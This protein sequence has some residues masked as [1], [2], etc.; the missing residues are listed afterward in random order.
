MSGRPPLADDFAA[1]NAEAVA[2]TESCGEDAWAR[3]VPEEGWSVGV[4]LHHVAEGH[5][6]TLRW[7]EG[8]AA[9]DGV[10]DSAEEIDRA[11]A[12]HAVRARSVTPSETAAL[13]VPAV[14]ASKRRSG[15]S[16][17]RSSIAAHRSGRPAA[18]ACP[19]STW[20]RCRRAIRPSTCRTP[21][22]RSP[23][24]P[25]QSEWS[26][27]RTSSAGSGRSEPGVSTRSSCTVPP[28]RAGG[29]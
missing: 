19:P 23:G 13:L 9:G 18:A 11:N 8:M 14:P 7:L 4:V 25:D 24:R 10:S 3:P 22:P 27:A 21:A 28:K 16:A 6:N 20:R 17:T 2:F 29:A 1:T 12:A 26:A 15:R 5:D